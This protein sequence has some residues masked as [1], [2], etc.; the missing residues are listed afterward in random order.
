METRFLLKRIL[1]QKEILHV[2]IHPFLNLHPVWTLD[3]V[4]GLKRFIILSTHVDSD[5]YILVLD[6]KLSSK[7]YFRLISNH[8]RF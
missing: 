8:H 7:L 4:S 2:Y 1:L 5:A 3:W 6:L